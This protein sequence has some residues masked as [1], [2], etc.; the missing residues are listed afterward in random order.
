VRAPPTSGP[1]KYDNEMTVFVTLID[2][3]YFEGGMSSKNTKAR[4]EIPEAPRPWSHRNI[5][6]IEC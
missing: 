1:V 4:E 5:I 3:A 2:A 6:L